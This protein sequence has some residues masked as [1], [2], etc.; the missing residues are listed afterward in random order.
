[1]AWT[2]PIT[3]VAG[4]VVTAA[5]MNAQVS[6]NLNFL[7]AGV[8]TPSG[9][10]TSYTPTVGGTGWALGNA[11]TVGAYAQAGKAT[12]FQVQITFGTTSTFGTGALTISLPV[13]ASGSTT[14]NTWYGSAVHS[15]VT[16]P[17]ILAAS[18]GGTSGVC[19]TVAS[20]AGNVTSTA[21]FTWAPGDGIRFTSCVFQAL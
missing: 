3:W 12:D 21:P 19:L 16:Y 17:V 18:A 1:M 5:T 2:T 10:W 11:T 13:Q 20:P 7:N 9:A 14:A 8:M 4:Q 15:G 6:G